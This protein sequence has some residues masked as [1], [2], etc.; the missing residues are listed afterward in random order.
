MKKDKLDIIYEDKF[1][2]VVNKPAHLLTIATSK[3]KERTLYHK[4]LEYQKKKNKNNKIFVVH[5]LDKDTSGLIMFAKD[6]KIKKALQDNWDGVKRKYI[7]VVEGKVEKKLDTIKSYLKENNN[8]ITYSTNDKN[9]KFA[10]TK[11]VLLN[12]SKSY[13]LLNIEILTGRKNQIRVHMNDQN[14]PIVGDKKY[15][16]KTNPLKRLGLHAY[17][18]KFTHPTNKTIIELE[19]NYPKE[20][21]NMFSK[22][23]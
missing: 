21:V 14:H 1:I 22:K 2:I 13:S 20:F 8:F 19:T 5:R 16:A 6:E 12:T 18:L 23:K 15:G 17:Y 3:E 9:G 4:V 10:I 7:A 11:Y